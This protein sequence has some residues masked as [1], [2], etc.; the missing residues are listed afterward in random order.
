M[1]YKHWMDIK[2]QKYK[3][4]LVLIFYNKLY[5]YL[6]PPKLGHISSQPGGVGVPKPSQTTIRDTYKYRSSDIGY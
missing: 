4:Q 1:F 5:T 6:H 3:S 2:N